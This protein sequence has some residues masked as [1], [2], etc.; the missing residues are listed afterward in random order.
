MKFKLF[1]TIIVLA[2]LS[3][4]LAFAENPDIATA[5]YLAS[6]QNN[7]LKVLIFLQGMPKGGDLHY[8]RVGGG[9]STAENLMRYG[10]GE[11]FCLNRENFTV[12]KNNNCS[13]ENL[14]DNTVNDASLYNATINNWS[15]RNFHPINKSGHDHFFAVFPKIGALASA[16]DAESLAETANRAG[17]QNESYLELMEMPDSDASGMLGKQIG[18]NSDLAAFRQKLLANGLTDIVSTMQKNM[19]TMEAKTLTILAC[20]TKHAQPG[21]NVKIHY[22]YEALREQPPEQ[23]FAQLLAGFEL[24]SKDPRFVGINLVQPEDGYISMR[25]YHQQ[26]QMIGFLHNIYPNVHISLHAGELN[27]KLVSPEGLRFHMREAIDVAHAERIGHGVSVAY[28]T[29][30]E[31]LLQEMAKKHVLV[32]INLSSNEAILNIKNNNHPLALYLD[33]HVPVAISTDDEGII[34]TTLT[35]EYQ[36]AILRYHLPYPT[37]KSIVRNS[38]Y[39]SFIPG[40]NLWQD[41]TYKNISKNCA[42]DTAGSTTPSPACQAF[43]KANEKANLQWDLENRFSQFENSFNKK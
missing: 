35:F 21:C 4:R 37:I 15:M 5:N 24:V 33:H 1:L 18:W 11:H 16:H 26:M 10:Y 17:E 43:L 34:R 40:K 20:G 31:Q 12:F 2:L 25:D 14:L 38:L 32:E 23:V 3:P 13:P 41:D 39:Y 7:P 30:A 27:S 8:H 29:N 19:A 28:E 36:K 9:G 42:H 22:Q 6:I